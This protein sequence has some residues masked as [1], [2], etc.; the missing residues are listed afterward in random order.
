[1]PK[2]YSARVLIAALLK[3]KFYVATQKGS[4]IKLIKKTQTKTLTVI[5]PNHKEIAMGTFYSILKQAEMEKEELEKF[6]K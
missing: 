2:L 4:H 6:M 5:I 3:A 1:M